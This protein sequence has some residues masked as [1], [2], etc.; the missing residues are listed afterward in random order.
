MTEIAF[1]I[2]GLLEEAKKSNAHRK[3]IKIRM[4]R[5]I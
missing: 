4:T 1:A 5:Q 2:N 3:R